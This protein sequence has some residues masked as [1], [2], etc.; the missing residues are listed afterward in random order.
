MTTEESPG[1]FKLGAFLLAASI[2]PEPYIVPVAVANFDKRINQNVFSLVIK[3]PFR[4][5][6]HIKIPR[7]TK[8]S[9]LSSLRNTETST[10]HT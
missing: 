2:E 6:D 8:T 1:P 10:K 9:S 4:I 5:S 3:K 7:R